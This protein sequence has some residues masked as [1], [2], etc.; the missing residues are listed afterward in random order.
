MHMD[1][2]QSLGPFPK[3]PKQYLI[4]QEEEEKSNSC[5]DAAARRFVYQWVSVSVC[6][7]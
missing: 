4:K 3:L 5:S 2:F 6:R 1:S 7:Q